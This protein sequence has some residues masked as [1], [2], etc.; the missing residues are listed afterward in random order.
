MSATPDEVIW[1]DAECGAYDGDLVAWEELCSHHDGPALELGAG[2]GRLA[3]HLARRGHDVVAVE[4]EAKLAAELERRAAAE[5]LPIE[6]VTADARELALGR[7]FGLVIVSMQFIQLFLEADERVAVLE[8]CARHLAPNGAVAAA[9]V[10]G[11][12]DILLPADAS[13][14][15]P[16]MREAGGF[17]YVSQPTG[18]TAGDGV[19]SSKRRRQRVSPEGEIETIDH[20]DRLAVLE[21]GVFEAEAERAGLRRA[22]AVTVPPTD[23]HVGSEIVLLEAARPRS[24]AG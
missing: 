16:D 9:I 21:E 12:P 18:S 24:A 11:V 10:E 7:R 8:V 22:G 20:V 2:T 15:L 17:V 4:R 14:A 1:H 19:I 23:L 13:A 6:V 5:G 3:L